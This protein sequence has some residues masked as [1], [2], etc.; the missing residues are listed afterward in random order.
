MRH[1]VYAT[2]WELSEYLKVRDTV[3]YVVTDSRFFN[4][5]VQASKKFDNFCGRV[6]YPRRETRIFDHP[7]ALQANQISRVS[8]PTSLNTPYP[9]ISI[10]RSDTTKLE[11]DDDL[12]AVVTLTTD[13]GDTTIASADFVLKSGPGYNDPPYDT[14]QLLSNGTQTN[15]SYTGTTQQAN[16]VDGIWGYHTNFADGWQQIDTVRDDP[17]TAGATTILVSG[18]DDAD[19]Q[20]LVPRFQQQ[21]VLRLGS[22]DTS[23]MVYVTG[24]NYTNDTLTVN[25]GVNG[26]TAAQVAQGTVI[27]VWRPHADIVNALLVLAGFSYR[28][29]DS[30]GS[31]RD[32][33]LASSG[34]LVLPSKL[35]DE[36]KEV[37]GFYRRVL[38]G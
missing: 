12:L 37:I 9:N 33:P 31:L 29:K 16:D 28:R 18:A 2:A 20:G 15:F 21:Q 24:I 36:V 17:L 10:S 25:R 13:N 14:I 34:V 30:V 35:P 5:A 4:F 27:E 19:E 23:E 1:G 8:L 22:G 26:S 11:L 38:V 3:G 32:Q 7:S 6:F